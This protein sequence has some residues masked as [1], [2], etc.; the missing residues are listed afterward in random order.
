MSKTEWKEFYR[1]NRLDA[2][3]SWSYTWV[4]TT[5]YTSY[6]MAIDFGKKYYQH[7]EVRKY[8]KQVEA[9]VVYEYQVLYKNN[10]ENENHLTFG[11][12]ASKDEW[13]SKF[14]IYCFI[15]LVQAT[16]RERE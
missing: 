8:F 13:D 1:V 15:E 10:F 3:G 12:F 16:K 11:Y 2:S 14:P 7:F 9:E 6:D 5:N 4:D